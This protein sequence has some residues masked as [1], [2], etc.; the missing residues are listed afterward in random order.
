MV[1]CPANYARSPESI[2]EISIR[3]SMLVISERLRWGIHSFGFFSECKRASYNWH[4]LLDETV[5]A[6][7][8]D[9]AMVINPF[10]VSLQSQTFW[11]WNKEARICF[12]G[13]AIRDH[14]TI[15]AAQ[16]LTLPWMCLSDEYER[17]PQVAV[18]D[19]SRKAHGSDFGTG[20]V[21]TLPFLRAAIRRPFFLLG[22]CVGSNRSWMW[23]WSYT[24]PRTKSMEKLLERWLQ[25]WVTLKEYDIVH[26]CS[27]P[28][29]Q[30][31]LVW[32]IYGS[33]NLHSPRAC[34]SH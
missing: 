31:D 9:G 20:C 6:L 17:T 4:D 28:A 22:P 8:E 11:V 26:K 24:V 3:L 19:T 2:H 25:E 10:P 7:C 14:Q 33:H 29:T 23:D 5:W 32:N 1:E 27:A 18:F 15:I 16:R 34:F 13:L 21:S 12:A 30:N